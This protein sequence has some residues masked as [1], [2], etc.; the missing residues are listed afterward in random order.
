MGPLGLRPSAY[1]QYGSDGDGD[2]KI[3]IWN[4]F[5]DGLASV[6]NYLQQ[7]AGMTPK[8]GDVRS[9]RPSP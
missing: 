1:L 7:T 8:P 5:A 2:G 6:A 3:D 4:S 9:K